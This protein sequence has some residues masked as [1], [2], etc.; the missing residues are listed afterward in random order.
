MPG[1]DWGSAATSKETTESQEGDLEQTFP[2]S[3]QREHDPARTLIPY[4]WPPET[5]DNK[6]LLFESLICSTSLW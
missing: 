5:R 2:Y 3:L 4:F 6:F 1:E